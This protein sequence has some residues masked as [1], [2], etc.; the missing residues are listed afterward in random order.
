[1]R[2]VSGCFNGLSYDGIRQ[3]IPKPVPDF[4]GLADYVR[5]NHI[6]LLGVGL[7]VVGMVVL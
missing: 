1:M 3:G 2:L 4:S 6:S 7:A 5:E